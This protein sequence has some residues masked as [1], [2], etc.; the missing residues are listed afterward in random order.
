[1]VARFSPARNL[2]RAAGLITADAV[3]IAF[4]YLWAL[5]IAVPVTQNFGESF[6]VRIPYLIIFI[7]V[8]SLASFDQHVFRSQTNEGLTAYAFAVTK[9]MADALVV[10]TVTMAFFSPQGVDRSFLLAFGI[11]TLASIL[12]VRIAGRIVLWTFRRRGMNARRVLIIGAN[13]RTRHLADVMKA[14]DYLGYQFAGF[15][16]DDPGRGSVLSG[17]KIEHLGKIDRLD[18]LLHEHRIDEVYISLPIR[19]Y[20][21]TIQHV[22]HLCEGEGVPVR[23]I[24][25][26]FPLRI[27]TNRLMYVEDIPLLSLSAVPEQQ[28]AMAIKRA[29]D[30][31]VSSILLL[32]LSPALIAMSIIIKLDSPGPIL[33]AQERVGQNQRRFR[34]LKFRSMVVNAEALRAKLEAMNEADGPVFKIRRDPR[35]TRVGRFIR[36][37]SIDE[38]PQL[39]NVWGGQMSLVGPRPPLAGEVAKYS[40]DQ[41]RRLSVKPGMT[42]LWQV[43]GRSDVSFEEWVELDLRYIDGWSLW[44]DFQILLKT[45]KAVA[46]GRGAA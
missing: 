13:E 41:R 36:K 23:F 3:C 1:M 8:W 26:L 17:H 46:G 29:A 44:L 22:A 40:W 45:F 42:G 2:G 38:F 43:S 14:R 37:F 7:L 27:A 32:L 31:V 5:E 6:V 16:E 34:M 21:E 35:I 20:Y 10:S 28:F 11:G 12:L 25:D 18:E 19:S 24:A 15:L 39:L 33:F 4:A 30:L 9:A